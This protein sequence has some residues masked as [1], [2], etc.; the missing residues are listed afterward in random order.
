M[1]VLEQEE[2]WTK[3][4]TADG[5]IGY[6]K[7]KKL[8][9]SYEEQ[10]TSDFRAAE[11]TSI[12]KDYDMNLLWHQVTSQDSN[13]ALAADIQDV[14]GV[15]VISPTWFSI[16]QVNDG[17]ISSLASSDYVDTAHQND[18]EVWGL[19]DNFSTDIDTDTV[20]GTT[21]S[22]ENLEGTADYRSTQL[23]AGWH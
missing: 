22:R 14:K 20:L 2:E 12:H 19:M 13:D 5:Y 4:L 7:S 15:N 6:M 1:T 3:V 21:T 9:D 18:M 11:Y 10:V 23:S 16:R 17:D 8:S